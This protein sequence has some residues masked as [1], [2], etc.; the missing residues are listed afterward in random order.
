M[1]TIR[2]RQILRQET[3]R[4]DRRYGIGPAC[5]PHFDLLW[6][7]GGAVTLRLGSQS[8]DLRAPAGL[9]LFPGTTFEGRAMTPHAEASICH[10]EAEDLAGPGVLPLR[11]PQDSLDVQTMIALGVR[12]AM[13]GET[14]DA[15][16]RLLAAVLDR[17]G[18]PQP[19]E[20]A[21][22]RI[23][24]A[25]RQARERLDR[26]RGLS[27]VAAQI[28]LSESAFRALHRATKGG[29]AG[30]HLR[31]LRLREAERLLATT[32]LSLGQIAATVGYSHA[33]SMAHAFRT[34]RGLSPGL[35]RRQARPFA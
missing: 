24:R 12:L 15:R 27:D 16:I 3:G 14:A 10:F 29:S 17:F 7:H 25:W 23:D 13:R 28:G 34:T 20:A 19:D 1:R 26:I 2:P 30:R 5:W 21:G 31:D 32:T 9:L 4:F 22:D 18:P 8:H 6:I 11:T 33:E 35:A